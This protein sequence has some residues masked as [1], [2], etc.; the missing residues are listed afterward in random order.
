MGI[1]PNRSSV[2]DLSSSSGR[3]SSPSSPSESSFP[4]ISRETETALSP[5]H[6]LPRDLGAA[7]RR[8]DDEELDR[9]VS[10]ALEERSRRKKLSVPK[11]VNRN[12]ELRPSLCRMGS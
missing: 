9:L 4:A 6:V 7:I 10:A 12:D 1:V 8:L 3:D 11:K 5:R 2:P